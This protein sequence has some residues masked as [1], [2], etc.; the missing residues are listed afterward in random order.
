M[1]RKSIKYMLLHV[2]VHLFV[3]SSK[4]TKLRS[5]EVP[6]R[7][8]FFTG[9]S[10]LSALSYKLIE[11]HRSKVS[12]QTIFLLQLLLVECQSCSRSRIKLFSNPRSSRN[13]LVLWI[14]N[15]I[16]ILAF[17][18]IS[19]RKDT[20]YFLQRKKKY[21]EYNLGNLLKV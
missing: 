6:S 8:R 18:M 13:S 10:Q 1:K 7:A 14:T 9:R 2:T 5:I 16:D 19:S 20:T 4:Q 11:P 17:I 12:L 3:I 15:V 21:F